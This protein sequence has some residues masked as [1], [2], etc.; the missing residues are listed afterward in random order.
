MRGSVLCKAE[1]SSLGINLRYFCKPWRGTQKNQHFSLPSPYQPGLKKIPSTPGKGSAEQAVTKKRE[2]FSW[3]LLVYFVPQGYFAMGKNSLS[4]DLPLARNPN[5]L[6]LRPDRCLLP[7]N[8]I[9]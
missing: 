2:G 9:P 1:G 6:I 8:L 4:K 7:Y 5:G 3:Y